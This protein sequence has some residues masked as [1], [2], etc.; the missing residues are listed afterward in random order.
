[1][2]KLNHRFNRE[3]ERKKE[4]ESLFWWLVALLLLQSTFQPGTAVS[5]VQH[6]EAGFQ[7]LIKPIG[8]SC[9]SLCREII[10]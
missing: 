5:A 10:R 8:N 9:R 7:N 4:D 2:T 1:M 3:S 6:S